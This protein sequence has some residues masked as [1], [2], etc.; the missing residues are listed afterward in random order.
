M[1]WRGLQ[2][3]SGFSRFTRSFSGGIL[4]LSLLWEILIYQEKLF[5]ETDEAFFEF[6]HHELMLSSEWQIEAFD[7]ADFFCDFCVRDFTPERDDI[8]DA[9]GDFDLSRLSWSMEKKVCQESTIPTQLV[10]IF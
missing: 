8:V 6:A 2:K 5:F 7:L 3:P 10:F 1:L 4:C 9:I